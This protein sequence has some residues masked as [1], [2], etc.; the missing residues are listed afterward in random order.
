MFSNEQRYLIGL[1]S[2]PKFGPKRLKLIFDNFPSCEEAYQAPLPELMKIGLPENL[3]SEFCRFRDKTSLEKIF[4]EMEKEN[5]NIISIHDKVYPHLLKEIFDP[6]QVLYYK[7]KFTTDNFNLAIVGS[8]K[9]SSY[10]KQC[11]ESL[12]RELSQQ[13]LT[14]V[15]GLALGIDTFVHETCLQNSGHTIAVLGSGID[16]HSLYPSSNRALA[17]RIVTQ[18]GLIISEFP[19]G[20][21]PLRYNFPQRNRIISGLSTATLV[22]EAYEKSGALITAQFALDQNRELLAVPGSI[23]SPASAGPNNLIKQGAKIVSKASDVLEIFNL[24]ISD[25]KN[26]KENKKILPSSPEEEIILRFL[27]KEPTHINQ[28]VRLS[29]LDTAQINSTLTIM[30][31]KG[32]LR[33][34]GNMEYVLV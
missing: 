7:G 18:D 14:L 26:F 20:T 19:L 3:A 15:S 31:M 4:N 10:G 12:S 30:E 27:S 9:F 17:E 32:M 2:F 34:L 21:E 33:N 29:G 6:P 23:F 8:R 1:S 5:I 28:L 13:G 25:I 24:D 16:K 11:T 22:I